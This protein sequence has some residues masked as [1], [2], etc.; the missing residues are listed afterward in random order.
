MKFKT[1]DL[2][3]YYP[4]PK[5]LQAKNLKNIK[6]WIKWA[7]EDAAK[8]YKIDFTQSCQL[9]DYATTLRMML[10]F[11]N[12]KQKTLNQIIDETI[13]MRRVNKSSFIQNYDNIDI[14]HISITINNKSYFYRATG[15]R[16]IKNIHKFCTQKGSIGKAYNKL[17]KNNRYVK[18]YNPENNE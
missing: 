15:K 1:K 18:P 3:I 9:Y 2:S 7:E 10:H 12:K 4:T 11:Y 5:E 16:G 8:L 17:I 14:R 13:K 6:L